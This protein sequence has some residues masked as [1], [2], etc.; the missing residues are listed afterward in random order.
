MIK[1]NEKI[2]ILFVSIGPWNDFQRGNNILT[3]W[4]D[5]YPCEAAQ[6]YVHEGLPCNK[7]CTNYFHI[8]N[9]MIV[10]SI[11]G[12]RAGIA[13]NMSVKEQLEKQ[14]NAELDIIKT[15]NI[16]K[17]KYLPRNLLNLFKELCWFLGRIDE[18]ALRKFI[19]DFSPDIVFCSHLFDISFYKI[20]NLIRKFTK[21]PMIAFTG[22][23]EVS[24]NAYNWSPLFWLRQ[25]ILNKLFWR[26][27]KIFSHYWTFSES[28]AENYQI[29][30][31]VPS[32]TL[33]KCA[34]FNKDFSP[35]N[36][37]VPVKLVYAGN[38]YC[39]RWKT[40]MKIAESINVINDN[41]IKIT[42][43]IYS[44][45][46]LSNTILSH[47]TDKRGIFIHNR[48]TPKELVEIYRN[49]DIALHIESFDKKYRLDTKESFS[50]KI[51]DLMSS[52]CAIMAIC[53]K[54]HNGLLYLKKNNAAICISEIESIPKILKEILQHKEIIQ[55][56]M[57]NAWKCGVKNHRKC[58]IQQQI[59]DKFKDCIEKSKNA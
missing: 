11:F 22:D 51:V 44:N 35:K 43:D 12:K 2:K 19:E 13:F 54:E 46:C 36:V 38:L 58:I 33:Y 23:S 40:I 56:Y 7:I 30:S 57:V 17:I 14:K 39:N 31:G 15:K 34:D 20:E 49:S 42:L 4:F 47:I 55:E 59:A 3:N 37:H 45:T 5:G 18:L 10:N 6:I 24:F 52:T 50:T 29:M 8:T 25:L 28:L 53:W 41:G 1:N 32:S 9:Q 27:I 16:S 21:V 26:H 48:V